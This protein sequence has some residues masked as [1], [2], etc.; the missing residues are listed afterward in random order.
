MIDPELA[1]D[2]TPKFIE[3]ESYPSGSRASLPELRCSRFSCAPHGKH[4]QLVALDGVVEVV[5]RPRHQDA[6]DRDTGVVL[7]VNDAQ[8]RC[9]QNPFDG[10]IE[11][12][13]EEVG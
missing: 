2:E 12:V 3:T 4:D 9:Q 13:I 1:D 7:L 8:G 11:F 5:A 6:K 10:P